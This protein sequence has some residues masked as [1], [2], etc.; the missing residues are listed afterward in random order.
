MNIYYSILGLNEDVSIEIVKSQY[1]KLYKIY[2]SDIS[3]SNSIQKMALIKEAY[4]MIIQKKI[5]NIP[6]FENTMNN[7]HNSNISC[8][9]TSEYVYYKQCINYFNFANINI[10]FRDTNAWDKKLLCFNYTDAINELEKYIYKSLYYFNIVC[11]QFEFC[12]WYNDSI[13]KIRI[14]NKKVEIIKI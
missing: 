1:Y 4:N 12:E 5:V 3:N 2:H 9:K 11:T 10:A 14:V 7:N 6:V 8:H 13:D